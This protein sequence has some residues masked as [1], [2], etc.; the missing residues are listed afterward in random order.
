MSVEQH[1]FKYADIPANRRTTCSLCWFGIL[2]NQDGKNKKGE[3]INYLQAYQ[4]QIWDHTAR[5]DTR[6]PQ[7][8]QNI[9]CPSPQPHPDTHDTVKVFAV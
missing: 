7:L 2:G 1:K 4:I 5:A 3:E 6:N 9:P 8:P